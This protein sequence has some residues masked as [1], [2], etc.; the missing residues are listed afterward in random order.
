[1]NKNI[2]LLFFIAA[3]GIII[4]SVFL[5]GKI[6][7]KEQMSIYDGLR[8]TS[9]I[10]FAV[11]G[12]W[13]ALL[14]PGKLS[15]A[16]GQKPYKEKANDIE[17]IKRLFR[18][19]IYSTVILMI[20]IGVSFGVPL[21]KQISY[22]HPYKEFFRAAS[23]GVI[24]FLTLLQFWSIILTLIPGDTIKDDLDDIKSRE[25]MLERMKPSRKKH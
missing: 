5:G 4:S 14:Y 25:E 17:Q 8:N 10:I 6:T 15:Q 13:I 3:A 11:M 20:V 7:F 22:L 16:F 2:R 23:F 9:A 24:A 12:A 19:M 21:A 1:M 18:P